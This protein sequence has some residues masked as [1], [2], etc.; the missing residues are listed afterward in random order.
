VAA[1]GISG[2]SAPD[3]IGISTAAAMGGFLE[4]GREVFW[5]ARSI[6]HGSGEG[7]GA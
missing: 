5:P 1:D 6:Q 2:A 7:N 3:P 4:M